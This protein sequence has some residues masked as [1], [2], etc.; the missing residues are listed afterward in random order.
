MPIIRF[1]DNSRE[2]SDFQTQMNQLFDNFLGQPTAASPMERVWAPLADVY[3]TSEE[4]VISVEM[5]GFSEK[6]IRLSVTGDV[7]VI[8][9]ERPMPPDAQNASF[10]RRERWFGR[11]ERAFQLTIPVETSKVVGTY[12]DGVLT[13]EGRG[14][15]A[16]GDQDPSGLRHRPPAAARHEPCVAAVTMAT[17]GLAGAVAARAARALLVIDEGARSSGRCVPIAATTSS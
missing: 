3:E 10:H 14:T 17:P 4:M 16:Q 13:A 1:R 5:P 2:L 15:E 12:R 8:Q 9:A 11:V 7:I 6:D